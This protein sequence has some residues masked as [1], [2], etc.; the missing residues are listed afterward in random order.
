MP[1]SLRFLFLHTLDYTDS[2]NIN[3]KQIVIN[4]LAVMSI[5]FWGRTEVI[6]RAHRT[7]GI[8]L[9]RWQEMGLEE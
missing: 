2:F 8:C 4:K 3:L 6:N 1:Q 9:C 7:R 5:E